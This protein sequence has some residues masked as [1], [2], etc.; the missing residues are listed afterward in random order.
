[1]ARIQT[2]REP[3]TQ[4]LLYIT[5]CSHHRDIE[6]TSDLGW[7]LKATLSYIYFSPFGR[8][9]ASKRPKW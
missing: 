3:V 6:L 8:I 5:P 2:K 7:E 9:L 1:M 4:S